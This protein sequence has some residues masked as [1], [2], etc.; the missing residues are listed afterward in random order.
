MVDSSNSWCIS[1]SSCSQGH[2][3]VSCCPCWTQTCW[4]HCRGK[5]NLQNTGLVLIFPSCELRMNGLDEVVLTSV[6]KS[7]SHFPSQTRKAPIHPLWESIVHSLFELI[8]TEQVQTENRLS[9][10]HAKP[11]IKSLPAIQIYSRS[12]WMWT[13]TCSSS[14]PQRTISCHSVYQKELRW[15]SLSSWGDQKLKLTLGSLQRGHNHG[16]PRLD[17]LKGRK[18]RKKLVIWII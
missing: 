8:K 13:H 4:V 11:L 6:L 9:L 18:K 3:T 7:C 5:H 17:V 16:K 2:G 10:N 14:R 1:G 15:F 12:C